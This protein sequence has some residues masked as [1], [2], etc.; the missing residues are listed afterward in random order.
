MTC[1]VQHMHYQ[2]I[3]FLADDSVSTVYLE[4]MTVNVKSVIFSKIF[5]Q[6]VHFYAC[7]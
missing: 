4:Q 5:G 7:Y 6:K 1:M 2:K 3:L